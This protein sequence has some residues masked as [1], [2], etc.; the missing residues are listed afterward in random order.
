MRTLVLVDLDNFVTSFLYGKENKGQ[1]KL[2][3]VELDGDPWL[4]DEDAE[5]RSSLETEQKIPISESR[6]DNVV[7]LAFNTI[8]GKGIS[9]KV[10]PGGDPDPGLGFGYLQRFARRLGQRL[11][12]QGSIGTELVL[13]LK[14]PQTADS[15]L[16]RLLQKAPLD[17]HQGRFDHVLL[18]SRDRGLRQNLFRSFGRAGL[19]PDQVEDW[20]LWSWRLDRTHTFIT[21]DYSEGQILEDLLPRAPARCWSRSARLS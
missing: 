13:T 18:A 10:N 6:V 12:L 8:T 4:V 2:P 20:W 11:G 16:Q 5:D 3:M 19:Y 17:A 7:V 9:N 1:T 14:M 21:R 15:A